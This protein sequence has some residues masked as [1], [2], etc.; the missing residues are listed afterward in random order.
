MMFLLMM[1]L[2]CMYTT[3]TSEVLC[4]QLAEPYE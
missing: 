1:A 2:L 3:L 4:K